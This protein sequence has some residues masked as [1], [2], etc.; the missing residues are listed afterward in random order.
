MAIAIIYGGFELFLFFRGDGKPADPDREASVSVDVGG[1]REV[2]EQVRR[3]LEKAALTPQQRR[4]VEAS[5]EQWRNDIFQVLPDTGGIDPEEP[6]GPAAEISLHYTGYLEMGNWR[7]AII[8][9]MEY[10]AGEMLA[11]GKYVLK[12]IM[13]DGVIVEAASDGDRIFVPYIE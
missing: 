7:M 11:Q 13:P 12:R 2:A 4:I 8:N 3:D 6:P 9:G 10:A 5:A 1:V